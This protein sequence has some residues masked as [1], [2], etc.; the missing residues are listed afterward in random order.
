M[1]VEEMHPL[2][3]TLDA[4]LEEERDALLK[5]DLD[6]LPDLLARKERLFDEIQDLTEV[7]ADALEGLH[8][9][10]LRNQALLESALAGIQ[11]IV[12]RMNTLRRV[13]NSLETY[14]NQGQRQAVQLT[15][16]RQLEK[17]A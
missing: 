14:T 4:L 11:S 2:F 12:D 1:T 7:Q 15:S 8:A 6:A 17:R 9:K 10:T 13:R 16:G 5:G 3:D